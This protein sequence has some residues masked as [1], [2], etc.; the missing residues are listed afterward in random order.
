MEKRMGDIAKIINANDIDNGDGGVWSGNTY[1]SF[2]NGA[3]DSQREL[4]IAAISRLYQNN[5]TG[6][7]YYEGD[8]AE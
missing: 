1:Q 8:S 5:H 6:I 7:R 2:R 3:T 4:D